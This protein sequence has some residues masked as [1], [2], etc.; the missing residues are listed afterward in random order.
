[1][2]T[3]EVHRKVYVLDTSVLISDPSAIKAFDEHERVI[4]LVVIK[5]L[6]GLRSHPLKGY[7]ARNALRLLDEIRRTADGD[8][9]KGVVVNPAGGIL[10]IEINHIDHSHLPDALRREPTNDTRILA[11]ADALRRE[12]REVIVVSKDMPMRLLAHGALGLT[13]EEYRREQVPDS[14]YTGIASID[15]SRDDIDDLYA[16]GSLYVDDHD[17]PVNTG[18]ILYGSGSSALA[19]VDTDGALR[20]IKADKLEAFGVRGRSAEQRIALSHLLDPEIGIVS[21][22]GS[23]GTGKS[24]LAIAAGL[25]AVLEQRTH[26]KVIV[27]RPLFSVGGQDLGFLPGTEAEKMGP[28]AGAVYDALSAITNDNVIDEIRERELLEVLPLTHIRGRTLT[29]VVVVLDEA[30]NLERGTI[31]TAISRLGEG[32]KIILTHDVAQRDNLRVGRHDGIAA[33]VERLK[34]EGLFAHVTLTRSERSPIAELATRL[35]DDA[36]GL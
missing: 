20:L 22:G 4:P 21:L 24:I 27:F 34:G 11:V 8:L 36:G 17:L 10:R 28:W 5:E 1:M 32:S 2:A 33:V 23:A 15:V 35:L 14:G 9:R 3:E 7:P 30:Q 13:A 29:N 19:K 12:G 31:L 18:V 6:E 25:E 16:T 26:K